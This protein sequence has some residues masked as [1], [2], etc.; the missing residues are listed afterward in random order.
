MNY[1]KN[2]ASLLVVS[3][4]LLLTGCQSVQYTSTGLVGEPAE[5]LPAEYHRTC[6]NFKS[7]ATGSVYIEFEESPTLTAQLQQDLKQQHL[8]ITSEK[9]QAD[10]QY[11]VQSR[12]FAVKPASRRVAVFEKLGPYIEDPE[13]KV[14]T[15]I[16]K[17]KQGARLDLTYFWNPAMFIG[18]NIGANLPRKHKNYPWIQ[19]TDPNPDVA[20]RL[21]EKWDCKPFLF[22]QAV[23]TTLT[24]QKSGESCTIE[25]KTWYYQ[26]KPELLLDEHIPL[27][28]KAIIGTSL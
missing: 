1:F 27:V 17:G 4:T 8:N 16:P 5:P 26:A 23:A 2:K 9:E 19:G 15:E 7:K 21:S 12:F 22:E 28:E 13:K 25:S 14:Y 18:A 11:F 20:C 24:E 3:G 6:E 10:Q